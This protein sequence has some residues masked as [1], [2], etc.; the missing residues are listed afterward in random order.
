MVNH[1][2][3]VFLT[4]LTLAIFSVVALESHV[5]AGEATDGKGAEKPAGESGRSEL[6]VRRVVIAAR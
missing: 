5:D 3:S 1:H 4:F 6:R 2:R